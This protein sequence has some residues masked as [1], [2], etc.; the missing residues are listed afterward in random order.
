MHP[1]NKN[2]QAAKKKYKMKM[3]SF[4]IPL[5]LLKCGIS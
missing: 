2:I 1:H 4:F 3:E 5:S